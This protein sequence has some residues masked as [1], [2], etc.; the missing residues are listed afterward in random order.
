MRRLLAST[1]G[2]VELGLLA[3]VLV[4]CAATAF[5]VVPAIAGGRK[6]AAEPVPAADLRAIVTAA[7]SCP[8]LNP[9]RLAAQI[10]V[11]SGFRDAGPHGNVA[12]IDPATWEAWRPS[13]YARPADRAAAIV[14]LGRWTCDLVGQLR[15]AGLAGDLWPAAVASARAGVGA[16]LAAEGIPQADR[17][18]VDTVVAY[19][20]WYADQ[21]EFSPQSAGADLPGPPLPVP[22]DL[23][24]PVLAAGRMC[25]VITPV[26]V[27]AQLRA[28]SGFDVNRR[29]PD[30]RAG[31]AQ[32]TPQLWARYQGD[33][34][35]SMWNPS[36]AIPAMGAAM[37][38]LTAELAVLG[39][40]PFV[41]ALGAYQWGAPAVRQAGGLPR[42]TVPQLADLA[43]AF[44]AEYERDP[45]LTAVA[46]SPSPSPSPV[47]A[48]AAPVR[49]S[50][51][52]SPSK[53]VPKPLYK[54]GHAYVIHNAYTGGGVSL[55][56]FGLDPSVAAG[57][58]VNMHQHNGGPNQQWSL[59]AA[60]DHVTIK[61]AHYGM[62]LGVENASTDAGAKIVV[63]PFVPGD[64]SQ[65][66]TLRDAGDGYVHIVNRKSGKEL[67]LPGD[68]EAVPDTTGNWK[69]VRPEQRD[70][71][72]DALDHRWKLVEL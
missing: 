52:P 12:G 51:S 17:E 62:A 58:Q 10:M 24:A 18:F 65:Q 46:P 70:A 1:R 34:G 13:A 61:N 11:A 54:P 7:L 56:V 49:P 16:V 47:P 40:D 66:W 42:S 41:L 3:L 15:A 6:L 68:E 27:A 50:P 23:V 67:D 43:P 19:S 22:H 37:C 36:E 31:I 28:L 9:P 69:G 33:P 32:F 21:P 48:T 5:V 45:R 63:Q 59:G 60:G 26:R 55:E 64:T 4:L 44:V 35:A 30:G 57:T 25:P 53:P 38:G 71:Q 72:K 29:S 2:R 39:G 20:R 14:A 8:S